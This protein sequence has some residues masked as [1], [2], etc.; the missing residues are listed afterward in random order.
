MVLM[1]LDHVRVYAAVPAGGP[2]WNLF[3]TRWVTHFC[4]PAFVFLAGT[5]TLLSA[6]RYQ[7]PRRLSTHLWRRGLLLILL[8][9]TVIRLSWTFN[10]DYAHF[11]MAGVI[12]A[13]GWSMIILGGLVRLPTPA[14]L[15]VGALIVA[16]H[17]IV[18]LFRPQVL[19]PLH[20]SLGWL[21][22]ALYFGFTGGTSIK[23][24]A[25]GPDLVVLYSII[26]WAGVMALGYAF[27]TV[28]RRHPAIRDHWCYAL[29]ATA[30]V[31]FVAL[32]TLDVYGDPSPWRSQMQPVHWQGH[33]DPGVMEGVRSAPLAF[34]NTTKYPAS[35]LFLL[36]T[37]GP[38]LMALPRLTS[39]EGRSARFFELFGRVPLFYYLLHI[40]VIH[41]AAIGV[42][43]VGSG[44]VPGWLFAN[45]P[46]T[47]QP[48]PP[49]YMWSL[50]LLY[51]VTA[52]VLALLYPACR[53]YDSRRRGLSI[54]RF[55]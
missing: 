42:S 12:W 50:P 5:S 25:D 46:M 37:I 16:G 45:H 3:F 52:L 32:R 35:L 26:P 8:E 48:P 14:I 31:L 41:L 15:A 33:G 43:L 13:I 47:E 55:I 1:A 44:E 53:W 23:L 28:L 34:L 51:A 4:A 18:D 24:G 36:M 17:N 7:D 22:N 2:E 38:L 39:A 11:V 21:W 49:G 19:L 27:G 9:I 40:P 54:G 10:F 29:G 20:G 6:E 30:I